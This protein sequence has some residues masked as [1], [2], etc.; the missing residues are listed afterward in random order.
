MQL[1][2]LVK[3]LLSLKAIIA[4]IGTSC[5]ILGGAC[6]RPA[7][8]PRPPS[9]TKSSNSGPIVETSEVPT[10]EDSNGSIPT[11]PSSPVSTGDSSSPMPGNSEVSS[12]SQGDVYNNMPQS[13]PGAP[14][15]GIT[16]LGVTCYMNASLQ[17]IA[18]LYKD[19][20]KDSGPLKDMIQQINSDKG[21]CIDRVY[22]E[23]FRNKLPKPAKQMAHSGKCEDAGEFIQQ[24]H[25]DIPFLGGYDSFGDTFVKHGDNKIYSKRTIVPSPD[26]MLQVHFDGANSTKLSEMIGLSN[27]YYI[28]KFGEK[29]KRR[30]TINFS[31]TEFVEQN[32]NNLN[33]FVTNKQASLQKIEIENAGAGTYLA[34]NAI[35]KTGIINLPDTLCVFIKRF[36][37]RKQK[38]DTEITGTDVITIRSGEQDVNYALSGFIIH[39]GRG[40]SGGHYVAYVKKGNTWYEANDK[41]ITL[42]TNAIEAS[43]KAYLF[44]YTKE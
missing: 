32:L 38:I 12:Q 17:I 19:N 4:M 10:I 36:N 41:I 1:V 5:M 25:S 39:E 14:I 7:S 31:K 18:A 16:N 21:G 37:A 20:I 6:S 2:R 11:P 23:K 15:R 9:P 29:N 30:V 42:V 43:Q 22:M 44:F 3:S 35:L 13:T 27:G 34:S 40:I 28:E 24:L 33:E 26:F 8:I